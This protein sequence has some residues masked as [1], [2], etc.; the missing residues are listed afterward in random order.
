MP[1]AIF[2]NLF[3]MN[4][5]GFSEFIAKESNELFWKFT[6]DVVDAQTNN[7]SNGKHSVVQMYFIE[8]IYI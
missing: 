7:W 4:K 8:L 6:S 5:I 1:C 3:H 2:G